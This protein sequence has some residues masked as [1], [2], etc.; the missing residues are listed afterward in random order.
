MN[1]FYSE[2][3]EALAQLH[4][5]AVDVPS[6]DVQGQLDWGPGQPDLVGGR[7]ACCRG[8]W[9]WVI[10]KVLSNLSHYVI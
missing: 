3:G 4:R 7:S 2:G 8:C 10:F 5:E 6:L 1:F 9:N